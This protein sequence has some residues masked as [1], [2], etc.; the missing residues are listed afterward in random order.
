MGAEFSEQVEKIRLAYDLTVE[1]YNKGIDPLEKV[2]EE[3]KNSADF[4]A[5]MKAAGPSLTGS[6]APGNKE[7]LIPKKGMAFLDA[8]CGANLAVYGFY[9]WLS[10]FY[11]VDISPA[12]IDTMQ[13]FVKKNKIQIGGLYVAEI[14]DMPFED[15][16]FDIALLIGVLEYYSLEYTKKALEEMNRVLKP[17][18]KLVVDIANLMHPHVDIMFKLEEYLKRPNIPKSREDF[19]KILKPLFSIDKID[20]SKVMLK[21]F[22]HNR[23]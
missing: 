8:G 21:Y 11:G 5:F 13:K 22:V 1:Q 19:E 16:T 14:I 4:K 6:N 18:A 15:N 2:P 17:D 10:T 12:L 7:Y 20:D 23:E 9:K 3:F